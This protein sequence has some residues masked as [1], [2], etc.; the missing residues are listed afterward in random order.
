MKKSHTT[1][2]EIKS[3]IAIG[4]PIVDIVATVDKEA[5]EKFKL[6]W[7]QTVFAN[8]ENIGIF[9]ELEKRPDVKYIPGGSVQNSMRVI[10][11]FLGMHSRG[12]PK[13]KV[14]MLGCTGDDEYRQKIIDALQDIGVTPLFQMNKENVTSRCGVAILDKERCLVPQIKASN[15]LSQDFVDANIKEIL[16]H[17]ALIIEGYFLMEQFE[18][19]KGLVK[20]FKEAGKP[21]IF[22]LSAVFCVEAHRDI[23]TEIANEADI[24]FCNMEECEALAEKK[25]EN[26][27]DTFLIAH[28]KLAK[29]DRYL[30]V[31]AGSRG[32]FVSKFNYEED[33]LDFVLQGFP[34]FIK[35]SEIVD[36]NGAGDSF[37]GGYTAAWMKGRS[38]NVCCKSGNAASGVIIKN[39]GFSFDKN[40]VIDIGE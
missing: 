1:G 26:Y 32:V 2:K 19:C 9:E 22:T 14:T 28:K 21:V 37:L 31:T 16:S 23:T 20:K 5:V 38:V 7:G 29:Q 36:T 27:S 10:S 30:I 33:R 25:G 13:Y 24:I 34:T 39:V 18:I 6:P 8:D 11:W 15:L 35:K 3:I 4:N 12:R 17:E 40:I